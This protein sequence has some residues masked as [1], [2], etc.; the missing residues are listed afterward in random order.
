MGGIFIKIRAWWET[1]DR[2]Q[3]VV[4]IFGSAFLVLLL[5]ATFF[6]STRPK[7]A[8][9]YG[10]LDPATMG[11]VVAEIQGMGIGVEYD[12]VSGTV[13][14]PDNK[15]DE[16]KTRLATS[17]AAPT[18]SHIGNE[19][20]GNISL[21]TSSDVEKARL[22]AIQQG[23]I[24]RALEGLENV[25]AATVIINPGE[26]GKFAVE[27]VPASASV[28]ITPKGGYDIGGDNAQAM[29]ALVARAVPGLNK[30]DVVILGSDGSQLFDGSQEGIQGAAN[31]KISAEV[32]AARKM[33]G[34][35]QQVLDR[36]CGPGQTLITTRVEMDWDETQ[37]E[38]VVY[39]RAEEPGSVSQVTETVG[40]G[41]STAGST[42]GPAGATA[43]T[44][45]P[46]TTGT[47]TTN[48]GYSG[49]QKKEDYRYN[50][51]TTKKEKTPGAVTNVAL[52][53]VINSATPKPKP[54]QKP[55]DVI[56]PPSREAVEQF[57]NGHLGLVKVGNDY[58]LKN[59]GK[60]SP[61]YSVTVVES[62]FHPV[63][64]TA[65]STAA[66]QERTQQLFSL[67][68]IAA[69]F[70]VAFVVLKAI[71]KVAKTKDVVVTA[72]AGG[73][74]LQSGGTAALTMGSGS[75]SLAPLAPGETEELAEDE[76]WVEE[77]D[78]E[79]QKPVRKKKKK[80]DVGEIDEKLNIP[81]E[82]IRK[83]A[84]E[85]PDTVALLLKSWLTEERR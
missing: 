63:D 26:K 81:L 1:A 48:S 37:E 18:S 56:Q 39:Q 31:K 60:D 30:K 79:T 52:S 21:M 59:A 47:G 67:L 61:T 72:M 29:A 27:D 51:K 28:T 68:P 5:G 46:N 36:W 45:P 3:R 35:L 66:A 17:G 4:S 82:Q 50:S 75:R 83:M 65:V 6:I 55:E 80:V 85:R 73:H 7:M 11:K 41:G 24:A 62:A 74:V 25:S 44:T 15:L 20:L 23:E 42:G 53:V 16:V 43:N 58:Q 64:N 34:E 2:T 54:G 77:E 70:I 10:G 38:S 19:A 69:L 8:V 78:E 13:R 33:R 40:D 71:A 57:L 49:T 22:V 12:T 84:E 76:T 32:S 14:V 9:A